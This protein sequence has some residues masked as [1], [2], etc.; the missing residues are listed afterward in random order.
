MKRTI[1]ATA[2]GLALTS[3][4]LGASAKDYPADNTQKNVRDRGRKTLTSGDQSESKLDMSITQQ[5]RKAIVAD[6]GLSTDAQNVKIITA[7]GVVTLRGPVSTSEEKSS[8][9]EKA[10]YI[11][12]VSRVDN[13]LE[14]ASQ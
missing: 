2:L 11:A 5:I 6:G 14:V 3:R 13:L 1:V 12:G 8:I 4:N 9:A 10:K 7:A